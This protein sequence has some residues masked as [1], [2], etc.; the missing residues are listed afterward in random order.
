M[1]KLKPETQSARREHILDAA[2]RCFAQSGF[3]RTTMHDICKLAGISPGALYVYFDS[4]EA[5]IAGLSERDRLEF[6][7]RFALVA[8]SADFLQSLQSLGDFYLSPEKAH[9]A[10]LG[11]EIGLE[12]T[13]NSNIGELFCRFDRDVQASFERLF[14]R[15]K[16]EGRIA[17]ALDIPALVTAVAIISDGLFWRRAIHPGFD[18]EAALPTAFAMI[19]ALL[20][21][22]E[23]R[24][25]P[26]SDATVAPAS[27]EALS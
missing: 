26:F 7:E 22:V 4:K 8:E 19:R 23:T 18:A 10:R 17:P 16:D 11:A 13:R 15:L 12:A 20:N 1:P 5:L 3:H 24:V 21:P 25:Q 6:A 27:P 9:K 2:E 14:Q